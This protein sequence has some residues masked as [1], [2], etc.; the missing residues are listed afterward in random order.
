MKHKITLFIFLITAGIV[1]AQT[2]VEYFPDKLN[3]QP[4]TANT[5]EPK[6]GFVFQ[7]N[8]NK[9]DLDIGNSMDIV[10]WKNGSSDYSVGA[11]LFTYTLL[12]KEANFHFPVDAVDYLFG[13]NF[14]YKDQMDNSSFGFRGRISHISTHFVDGHY[15]EITGQWLNGLDPI[16]YSREFIELMPFYEFD[17]IRC[18]L[19]GTY[20]FHIDPA[21]LGKYNFQFGFD[22]F[23]KNKISEV[24]TPFVGYDFRLVKVF[25]NYSGNNSFNMGIKL[26]KPQGK[27]I[28]VFYHYYSGDDLHGQYV[29]F[30]STYSAIGINLD[31]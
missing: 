25:S 21:Q 16:V 3:I 9:L 10:Q 14:S 4:F 30:K 31:L 8:E 17:N 24:V 19:G 26:G 27:G 22:Y 28:S 11:D 7:T 20:T 18:Y 15:D 29:Y 6:L 2:V 5:L 12:R 1:T 23:M 13:I